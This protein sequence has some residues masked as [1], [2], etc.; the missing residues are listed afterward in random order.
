MTLLYVLL[1]GCTPPTKVAQAEVR[2]DHVFCR[3]SEP[4]LIVGDTA[5]PMLVEQVFQG[6]PAY[7]DGGVTVLVFFETWS[8]FVPDAMR[9]VEALHR[10]WADVGVGVVGLTHL[11]RDPSPAPVHA[12]I[13]ELG[14]TFPVAQDIGPGGL[15]EAAE[16]RGIPGAAAVYDGRF[17]WRGHPAWL[18]DEDMEAW[19][20]CWP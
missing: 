20:T 16:T 7:V 13:R 3:L 4:R 9:R 17:V 15:S 18:F 11:S 12:M 6:E 1:A 14:L 10:R 2:P 8:P 5:P 19:S